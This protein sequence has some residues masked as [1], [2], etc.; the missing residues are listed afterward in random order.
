MELRLN[1]V[2]V[3]APDLERARQFYG[4][5]LGLRLKRADRTSLA[6]EG[7][8]FALTI[9]A[10]ARASE[11]SG[12]AEEAGSSVAFAVSSL[13]ASIAELRRHGVR[14]LHAEPNEG[15]FGRYVAFADPFGTVHE[16]V[17]TR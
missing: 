3:F 16:L 7:D 5:V 9:F 11:P 4:D 2:I 10:C 14:L 13:D 1:K 6:F 15:P 8:G 17:E 12:Y